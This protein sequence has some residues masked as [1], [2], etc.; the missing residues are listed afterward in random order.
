MY[1]DNK[2]PPRALVHFRQNPEV[3]AKFNKGN[4]VERFRKREFSRILQQTP[5]P[6]ETIAHLPVFCIRNLVSREHLLG[7]ERVIP[8]DDLESAGLAVRPPSPLDL[9]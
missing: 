3:G 1:V 9:S 5:C 6:P 7:G 8:G 2:P 4:L